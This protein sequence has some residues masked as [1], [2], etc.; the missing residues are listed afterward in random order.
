MKSLKTVA[1]AAVA[2]VAL[3]VAIAWSNSAPASA[4]PGG[5]SITIANPIPLPITIQGPSPLAITDVNRRVTITTSTIFSIPSGQSQVSTAVPA[6]ACPGGTNF[7]ATDLQAAPVV[8]GPTSATNVASLPKWAVSLHVFQR[9]S[10][11]FF[12]PFLMVYGDGAAHGSTSIPAGQLLAGG[13]NILASYVGGGVVGF[14]AAIAV[15]VTGYCG[16]P[17]VQP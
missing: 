15:H 17:F 9:V 3:V 13:N 5:P 16:V 7:L 2:P 1:A 4:Q 8:E 11:G 14:N 10:N 6:P 12:S